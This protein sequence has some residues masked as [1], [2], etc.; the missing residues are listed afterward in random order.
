MENREF[1]GVDAC[2][3]GGKCW[4]ICVRLSPLAKVIGTQLFDRSC[5]RGNLYFIN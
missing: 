1:V 2:A 3:F 4:R 5:C